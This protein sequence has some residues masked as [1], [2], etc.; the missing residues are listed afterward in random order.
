MVKHL[1]ANAGDV[2]DADV[3]P[4]SGISPGGGNGIPLQYSCQENPIDRGA[5]GATVPANHKESDTTEQL[6]LSV[7]LFSLHL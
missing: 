3:I 2:R 1:L 5:W 6:T 7:T 4:G